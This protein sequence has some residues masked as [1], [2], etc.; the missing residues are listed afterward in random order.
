MQYLLLINEDESVYAGENGARLMEEVLGKHM[1]FAE[2]L[3]KD[4][5]AFSG[6]RLQ[7]GATATTIKWDYGSHA[8]HDGPFA[9][10]H[11]ELG[12]YYLI[13]VPDLDAALKYARMIPIPG[14]GAIE[15]RP[16]WEMG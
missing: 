10:T 1:A 14:K 7:P 9:E 5:V 8:L 13:D 15:V 2:T 6:N 4:G 12:G 16:V 11:E 3:A